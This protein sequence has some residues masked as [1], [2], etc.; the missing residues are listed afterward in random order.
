MEG[1][2]WMLPEMY[3]RASDIVDPPETPLYEGASSETSSHDHG[4]LTPV[5]A[6]TQFH[7]LFEAG[8]KCHPLSSTHYRLLFHSSTHHAPN[9]PPH[10]RHP[11]R[12]PPSKPSPPSSRLD[13]RLRSS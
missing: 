3:I 6:Q 13:V 4:N 2:D 12:Q 1:A 5:R 8:S 10:H 11:R 9:Q 7:G